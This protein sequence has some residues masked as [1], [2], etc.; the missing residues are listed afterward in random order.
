LSAQYR[1]L[2]LVDTMHLKDMLGP[3]QPNSDNRHR[4]APLAVVATTRS[5]APLMPSGAVHTNTA[6]VDPGLR[7]DDGVSPS[8][9]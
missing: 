5:P 9:R 8:H 1:R 3:I 2:M 7:R 6:E 4:T